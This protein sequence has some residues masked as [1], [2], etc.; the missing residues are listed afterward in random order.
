MVEQ[1]ENRPDKS[2]LP[3][4]LFLAMF[5]IY[6]VGIRL[7]LDIGF[8]GL[9]GIFIHSDGNELRIALMLSTVPFL[10]TVI[11]SLIA[12]RMIASGS[13]RTA[14]VILYMV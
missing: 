13:R 14:G 8:S 9:L 2:P 4:V 6:D 10:V 7:G 11:L 12:I 3:I 1:P 5:P